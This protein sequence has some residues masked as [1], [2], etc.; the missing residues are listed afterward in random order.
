MLPLVES[1]GFIVGGSVSRHWISVPPVF[2]VPKLPVAA[3]GDPVAALVAVGAVGAVVA[4]PDV[5]PP[6]VPPL[7]VVAVG[8]PE[9]AGS[10][11][12]PQ[13]ANNDVAAAPAVTAPNTA[14]KRRRLTRFAPPR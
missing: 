2:G 4:L 13:A 1:A 11:V 10:F 8:A 6:V 3:T 14:T 12:P 5:V 7:R 9:A